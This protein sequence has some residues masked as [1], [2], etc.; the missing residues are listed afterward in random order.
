MQ[1]KI[2][3][4]IVSII[5]IIVATVG[6]IF[7]SRYTCILGHTYT[8]ATC[9][10]PKVCKKCGTENGS[11]APH[12]WIEGNC[13]TPKTCYICGTTE[14]DVVHKWI[15][16]TCTKPKTC[17]VCGLTEGTH[18]G[19]TWVEATCTKPKTCSVCGTTE[20]T[21]KGHTWVNATCTAPKTCSVCKIK[22]GKPLGHN[23]TNAKTE[24]VKAPT[25]TVSGTGKRYCTVC[26]ASENYTIASS[27]HNPG[28]WTVQTAATI[29][30][31][32][33]KVKKC[34]VCGATVDTKSYTMSMY[35][36]VTITR[37]SC[38]R[39]YSGSDFYTIDYRLTNNTSEKIAVELQIALYD[40]YG[41]ELAS[42][43]AY[44]YIYPNSTT[45]ERSFI[46]YSSYAAK[47]NVLLNNVIEAY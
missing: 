25:C 7:I 3:I 23:Y 4:P 34:T 46:R 17:S 32:G 10:S 8:E 20:G 33:T 15:N 5:I 37:L 26:N 29:S 28:D 42:T 9:T 1:N 35:D 11:Y 2:F 45:E 41:N 19:H 12:S 44:S 24:V 14:G 36:A 43:S 22:D 39:S 16:A 13:T 21:H 27:G 6:L 18:N 47:Y 40:D 30:Q 31:Q 38:G